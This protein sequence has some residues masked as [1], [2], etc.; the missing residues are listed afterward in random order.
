MYSISEIEQ[1]MMSCEQSKG[2]SVFK[3]G[4]LV[5]DAYVRLLN[6][7]LDGI[8][9]GWRLPDNWKSLLDNQ[10]PYDI[11]RKYHIFHDCGKPFCLTIDSEGRRHFPDH[12]LVSADICRNTHGLED[13]ANLVSMDMD[14]HLLKADGIAEFAMR[15]ECASLILTGIAEVHAN[16]EMFGGLDSNNFKIKAKHIK[17]RTKQI[18]EYISNNSLKLVA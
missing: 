9:E 14:I 4:C 6:E 8:P 18:F 2:I 11:M 17:K 7:H 5:H 15:P 12:A 13:I 16:A 3:H 1:K 10:L